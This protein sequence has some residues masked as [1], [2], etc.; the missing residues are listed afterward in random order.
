MS[1]DR[2][3]TVSVDVHRVGYA[4]VGGQLEHTIEREAEVQNS[5]I[6]DMF[7][8]YVEALVMKGDTTEVT[9]GTYDSS[10]SMKERLD[11]CLSSIGDNGDDRFQS[12]LVDLATKLNDLM[13]GSANAGTLI[14]SQVT[15]TSDNIST[16]SVDAIVLLKLDTE[17]DFRLVLSDEGIDEV[18][19]NNAF[20][21]YDRLQKGAIYP[22]NDIPPLT[23]SGDVKIFQNSYSV[24]FQEFLE[25]DTILPSGLEQAR[26]A[27]H[28]SESLMRNS[29]EE[30]LIT[31]GFSAIYSNVEEDGTL[32]ID[33]IA[34]ALSDAS[35]GEIDEEDVKES[36]KSEENLRNIQI[37]AENVPD[38]IKYTVHQD[39][40]E[41]TVKFP[42]SL[43]SH[44]EVDQDSEPNKIVIQGDRIEPD[45]VDF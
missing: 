16:D 45:Y 22:G 4:P 39:G 20:P 35:D 2:V 29:Q 34:S 13:G 24:Y 1:S 5:N 31:S 11:Q 25:C 21:P 12:I 6:P 18:S 14:I 44:V 37:D 42:A 40:K 30:D 19:E 32:T 3:E 28:K 9:H 8:Y 26:E 36:F 33:S 7:R 23:R 27:L 15:L 43:S 38:K 17:E 41:V 10:S